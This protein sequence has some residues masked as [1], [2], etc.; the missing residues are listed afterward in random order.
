M[1]C[2]LVQELLIDFIEGEEL[3]NR[4]SIQEHLETCVACQGEFKRLEQDLERLKARRR[5]LIPDDEEWIDF[6]P[7]I[8]RKISMREA[9]R[10]S[11]MPVKRLAPIL[12]LAAVILILFKVK[13]PTNE[14]MLPLE[15]SL[16]GD[17]N[18]SWISDNELQDMAQLELNEDDLYNNLIGEDDPE[19][20]QTIEN[21]QTGSLDVIDQLIELT[22][23][24]QQQVFEQLEQSLL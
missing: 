15:G 5:E 12:A 21:W 24:E 9:R 13:F 7:G 22:D 3:E 4:Q 6:L 23:E 20:L 11:W 16:L 19:L 14:S 1:R 10:M 17:V 2:D 18:S 8:R